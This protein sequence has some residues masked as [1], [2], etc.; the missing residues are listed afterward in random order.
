MQHIE[1]AAVYQSGQLIRNVARHVVATQEISMNV[2]MQTPYYSSKGDVDILLE[3]VL[4]NNP[5]IHSIYV[6]FSLNKKNDRLNLY[7]IR[8]EN[9]VE[10]SEGDRFASDSDFREIIGTLSNEGIWSQPYYGQDSMLLIAYFKAIYD[11]AGN[12]LGF[13]SCELSLNFLDQVVSNIK[14]GENGFSFVV[15]ETGEYITHPVK[16]W[17][18]ARNIFNPSEKI[19][20]DGFDLYIQELEK[21]G[22]VTGFAYPELLDFEKAWFFVAP[23]PHTNWLVINVVP[24]KEMFN[25]LGLIF[26]KIIIVSAVGILAV[27][28]IVLLLFRKMLSPLMKLISSFQKLSFLD[29]SKRNRK[30]EIDLLNDSFKG[31]QQQYED[32]LKEQNKNISVKKKYDR[33]LKAAKEIQTSIIPA[34]DPKFS[35]DKY[36]ELYAELHPAE[37]IGGDLY[38]YFFIDENHLLF[39]MGDVSGKGIPAA[40]FMAVAHTLIKNKATYVTPSRIIKAVNQELYK[41]NFSQHFLTLFIGIIDIRNGKLLYCNAGHNYPFLIRDESVVKML[42]STHGLPV[43]LYGDKGYGDSTLKLKT[44][45]TL[46]L[47]TDGVIDSKDSE[48]RIYG[49]DRLVENMNYL[50]ELRPKEIVKRL[51]NSLKVFKGDTKQAD[52]ISIMAVKYIKKETGN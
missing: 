20:K 28:A 4:I 10:L 35:K 26:R 43:G 31:F 6:D 1:Q 49:N 24:S 18:M 33:D 14:V 32:Y 39:S 38:D 3:G 46:V 47:Y 27:L 44:G 23:I 16:E 11:P 50:V 5:V 7:A 41:Q 13:V 8:S 34:S 37:S 29:R 17:I 48:D 2:S 9:K 45:D 15:S 12:K 19:F 40:L 21:N 22:T 30:N 42:Q 36:I 25:D 52:D 51:N